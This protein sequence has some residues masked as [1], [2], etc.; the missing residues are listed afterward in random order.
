MVKLATEIWQILCLYYVAVSLKSKFILY[1]ICF[2]HDQQL[3]RIHQRD[4]DVRTIEKLNIV[5][6]FHQEL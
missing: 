2:S 6:N 5:N 1:M 4:S 3:E